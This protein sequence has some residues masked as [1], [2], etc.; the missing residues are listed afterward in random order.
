MKLDILVV[1]L[2]HYNVVVASASV[3]AE[4]SKINSRAEK[5]SYMFNNI[6]YD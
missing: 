4:S 6:Y 3:E 1:L 5:G 2:L